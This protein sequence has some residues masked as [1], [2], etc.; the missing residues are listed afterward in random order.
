MR[1]IVEYFEKVQ[2][3]VKSLSEERTEYE[4]YNYQ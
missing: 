2:F 3:L 1:T 4:D